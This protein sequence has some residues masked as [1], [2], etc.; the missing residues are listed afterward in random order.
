[1]NDTPTLTPAEA[2]P[3]LETIG[4]QTSSIPVGLSTR[5]LEH[6]S[7][8]LYSS[9]QK[10]FEELISNGWDAG[11]DCVD[12]RI[13]ADLKAPNATLSVLDNGASMDEAGLRD[14][15]RIAFS[16][17]E[18]TPVQ[19]GRPVIGKFGIGKLA[20]YVLATKLTY[21]CKAPDG[22]IRRV[23][24]DYGSIDSR[25]ETAFEN[26]GDVAH[27]DE[28]SPGRLINDLQLGLYEV[29]EAEV[30]EALRTVCDGPTIFELIQKGVPRPEGKLSDDE[31]GAS[32]A[33]FVRPAKGTWTLVVLSG[34]KRAGRGLKVGVLKR[35]LE[36]ALPIGSEMAISLN[37]QLLASSKVDLPTMKEWIIGPALGIKTIELDEAESPSPESA[38]GAS[39][40]GADDAKEAKRQSAIEIM[41][42]NTPVPHVFI[43][44][45][46]RITGCARLFLTSLTGG[47]SDARGASNGFYVNVLGRIVNQDPAFG[48]DNLNHAAWARFRMTVR[49]DGLNSLLTIN[50]EQFQEQ[51]ELKVFRAFLRKV[52]N[53]VRNY[54]DNDKNAELPD[55]GDVLVRALG[56][57]SLTPLRNVVMEALKSQPALPE[58][59]DERGVQDK[60]ATFKSWMENTQDNIKSALNQVKYERLGDES[61]V[62]FR[63]ADS[64]I[65]VNRDHPFVK[66]HSNTKA[67][68]ELLLTVGMVSLLADMYALDIGVKPSMLASIRNY[69]DRLMRVRALQS[70][71]SGTYIA[72]L[73]RETEHDSQQSKRFETV[74]SDALRYIGFQ[75]QDLAKPG[76]PEGIA[77]AYPTPTQVK[78]TVEDPNPPLYSF[79]FDAKSSKHEVAKTGN[80]SLDGVVEHKKRYRANY[81]LVVAPDFSEG[82]LAVR[83]EQQEVTPMT[84]HALGKLL[85]YTVEYGAIPVTK[86]REV[87]SFHDPKEVSAW[88]EELEGWIKQKRALTFDVFIEALKYLKGQVP[89]ELPAATIALACRM[90]L[91]VVTVTNEDVIAVA[92]G[93]SVLIPDLV[94][95]SEDK[96]VVH[97]S[98][99]RVAATFYAQLEKLQKESPVDDSGGGTT[100]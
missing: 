70:R 3:T 2:V 37:G 5:F 13:S 7:E 34:L 78:P 52:F 10:A 62:K 16:P 36:S 33:Q 45:I 67:E 42:S 8:Q 89:D 41:S 99:E 18:G 32:K 93:L 40:N 59:F 87:F 44:G 68:K 53:M 57:P 17:K 51:E 24:M 75:V 9:P 11:A 12:I 82:A 50:R 76:E 80:I 55:G 29:T 58:L 48:D 64:S 47:K 20:T 26:G 15:W 30:E 90:H 81:A 14:L 49:A 85:E 95:I 21:I 38:D 63:V 73:L 84:T 66:E 65:V 79:T 60:E 88:T 86:L 69:R 97:A 94:G 27:Q 54:Y 71:K 83:C 91:G 28:A 43:P 19:Y 39:A 25:Q 31:Y 23:T 4:K 1:M 98:A 74:V 46:G 22:V 92:H 72:Q 100:P 6:F 35:M 96:I 77:S 61:F 56:V